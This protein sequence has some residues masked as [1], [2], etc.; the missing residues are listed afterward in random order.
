MGSYKVSGPREVA[1]K[2][3]GQ[4]VTDIELGLANIKALVDAGHISPE[5]PSTPKIKVS[6]P[7]Q[8]EQE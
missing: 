8:E 4:V 2:K 3:P 6:S 7:A 5:V 1:G